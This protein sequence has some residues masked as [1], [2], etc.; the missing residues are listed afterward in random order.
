MTKRPK[1]QNP[2]VKAGL[3]GALGTE[4]VAFTLAG[5]WGGTF[6]DE[7][8]GTDPW[9]LL[10][11]LFVCLMGAAIHVYQITKRFLIDE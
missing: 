7:R 1:P 3:F 6:I 10:G 11:C 5:V 8:F 9:G 4:F 2:W